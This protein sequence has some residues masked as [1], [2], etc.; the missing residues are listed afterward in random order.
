MQCLDLYCIDLC[1]TAD[2]DGRLTNIH[3]LLRE[4]IIIF[5]KGYY[6]NGS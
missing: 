6:F 1:L 5:E 3:L 4:L 2:F